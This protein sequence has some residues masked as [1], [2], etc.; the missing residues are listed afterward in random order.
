MVNFETDCGAGDSISS[1]VFEDPDEA[2][3]AGKSNKTNRMRGSEFGPLLR[4]GRNS[5]EVSLSCFFIGVF[6]CVRGLFVL[7]KGQVVYVLF[8]VWFVFL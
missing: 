4:P 2:M 5:R 3:M 6:W 7:F 1:M 8:W